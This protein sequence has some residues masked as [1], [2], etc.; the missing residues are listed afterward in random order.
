MQHKVI[1][2]P[3]PLHGYTGEKKKEIIKGPTENRLERKVD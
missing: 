2:L 1:T 3:T